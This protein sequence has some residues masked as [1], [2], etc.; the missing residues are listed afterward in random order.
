MS[1]READRAYAPDDPLAALLGAGETLRARP[2]F[3]E[4][5]RSE[6]MAHPPVATGP[7]S[8]TRLGP[9]S[10]PVAVAAVATALVVL[11]LG[12]L[13]IDVGGQRTRLVR[14]LMPGPSAPSEPGRGLGPQ[15]GPA[16]PAAVEA[17]PTAADESSQEAVGSPGDALQEMPD[18]A[19][20]MPGVADEGDDAERV[21]GQPAQPAA[22]GGSATE[23]SNTA[24]VDAG[25]GAPAAPPVVQPAQSEVP[26]AAQPT[27]MPAEPTQRPSEKPTDRPSVPTSRP[28]TKTPTAEPTATP[29]PTEAG[30]ALPPTPTAAPTGVLWPTDTPGQPS[31]TP[32]QP[33]SPAPP[34]PPEGRSPSDAAPSADAPVQ[35]RTSL[36]AALQTHHHSISRAVSRQA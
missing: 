25:A 2:E 31:P 28:P 9:L 23:G 19:G 33:P 13:A 14:M 27:A 17:Q 21:P 18:H 29:S 12:M 11:S 20:A 32:P 24:P 15:E 8:G 10:G 3:R 26:P 1:R 36:A 5:L 35:S 30:G 6:L 22:A 4:E 16:A 7:L 34:A